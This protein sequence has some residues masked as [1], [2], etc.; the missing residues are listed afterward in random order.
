MP[1]LRQTVERGVLVRFWSTDTAKG[2]TMRWDAAAWPRLV[3]SVRG[4]MWATAAEAQWLLTPDSGLWVPEGHPLRV[5]HSGPLHLRTVYLAPELA[6]PRALA[7]V[8]VEPL[9]KELV[10]EACRIGPLTKSSPGERRL[11]VLLSE[12]TATAREGAGGLPLPRSK[13]L[14]AVAELALRN[15]R[16]GSDALAKEVGTS[17]RSLERDFAG[18]TGISLGRWLRRARHLEALRLIAEG[19]DVGQ[20]AWAVGYTSPSAF[21]H[22]FHKSLGLKPGT[23]KFEKDGSDGQTR[24]VD[25][26]GMNRLL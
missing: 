17:R 13:R 4:A 2:A 25:L 20:A 9:L 11:A 21:T 19:R 3:Y 24:T 16:L 23:L 18:E 10:L 22:A 7:V 5:A 8:T 15:V 26:T 1:I 12:R 14:R 6:R